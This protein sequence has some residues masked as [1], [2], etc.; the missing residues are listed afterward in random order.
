MVRLNNE[1]AGQL[2]ALLVW[3]KEQREEIDPSRMW[4]DITAHREEEYG[5]AVDRG[6]QASPVTQALF[7]ALQAYSPAIKLS[8]IIDQIASQLVVD[9]SAIEMTLIDKIIKILS[10]K[11]AGNRLTGSMLAQLRTSL[12]TQQEMAQVVSKLD[13]QELVCNGC[14]GT[15]QTGEAATFMIDSHGM[16]IFRCIRCERPVRQ[17]CKIAGCESKVRTKIEPAKC[18]EHKHMEDGAVEKYAQ[19]ALDSWQTI[20]AEVNTLGAAQRILA[21]PPR[22]PFTPPPPRRNRGGR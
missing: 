10:D 9:N 16:A 13:D 7:D 4:G 8:H 12:L 11:Y 15:F 14:G 6:E 20:P 2:L 1:Q 5:Q 17:Q 18:D 19:I 3:I 22:P 21:T